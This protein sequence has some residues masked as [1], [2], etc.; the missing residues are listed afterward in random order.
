M[1]Y[2]Y[3]DTR[4]FDILKNS[5][6]LIKKVDNF[7]DPFELLLGIDVDTAHNIIQKEYK[8]NPNIINSWKS[9]LDSKNIKYDKDSNED[10]LEKIIEFQ[11]IDFENNVPNILRN[12][13]MGVVCFSESP[14]VIQMWAHYTENHT[15]IVVGIE[16]SEFVNDKQAIITVCY[17]DKMV[18]FP[19]TMIPEKLDQYVQKYIR[20][21]LGRKETHWNYEKEVRL[22]V[23]LE[24][25]DEDGNYY[26][27]IPASS[28]KEIYLGLRSSE[29]TK[30]VAECIKQREEYKY[31][32][33]YKMSKHKRAYKFNP[34][35]IFFD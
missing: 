4:G 20:D 34:Q 21:A 11:I 25:K 8:E 28:I 24:E 23:S 15:G 19:I 29:T 5:R 17:R 6:L 7:N 18:L 16:E 27:I 31:L 26:K 30:L 14:D 3:C 32:K 2:K 35:E 1:L 13:E 10:I 22:Y 33:V 12:Q 9:L